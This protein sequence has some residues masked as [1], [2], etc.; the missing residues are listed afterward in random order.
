[1]QTTSGFKVATNEL[2]EAFKIEYELLLPLNND[3]LWIP[4]KEELNDG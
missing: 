4:K 1:M 3:F 2:R